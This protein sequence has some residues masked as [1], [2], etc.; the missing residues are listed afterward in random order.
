MKVSRNYVVFP[1]RGSRDA[2]R[3]SCGMTICLHCDTASEWQERE[4]WNKTLAADRGLLYAIISV[5]YSHGIVA[6]RDSLFSDLGGLLCK[7]AES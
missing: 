6:F 5:I 2:L 4:S 7:S 3:R 1:H